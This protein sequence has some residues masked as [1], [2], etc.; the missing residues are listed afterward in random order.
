MKH[1]HKEFPITT[2]DIVPDMINFFVSCGSWTYTNANSVVAA[3]STGKNIDVQVASTTDFD[4]MFCKSDISNEA[5]GRL[6]SANENANIRQKIAITACQNFSSSVTDWYEQN[7]VLKNVSNE[8]IG[9][10]LSVPFNTTS[11]VTQPYLYADYYENQDDKIHTHTYTFAIVENTVEE[12]DIGK[13]KYYDLTTKK[14]WEYKKYVQI[15]SV[16][17]IYNL[18]NELQLG[19]ITGTMSADEVPDVSVY[20]ITSGISVT[21]VN[22]ISNVYKMPYSTGENTVTYGLSMIDGMR[23]R[24]IP[25]AS[26]S[27]K[28]TKNYTGKHMATSISMTGYENDMPKIPKYSYLQSAN[29]LDYGRNA[30]TLNCLTIALP[31]ALYYLRDPD[32]LENY[33]QMWYVEGMSF[34]S[35]K[36][37]APCKRYE[38]GYPA[39]G[40]MQMVYPAYVKKGKCGYD[41]FSIPRPSDEVII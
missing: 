30:N 37:I 17:L 1:I 9:I 3:S 12:T 21:D 20:D 18:K 33:S 11:G 14:E 25:W 26:T 19:A 34:I 35:L 29:P 23:E 6:F 4:I 32:I 5:V 16:F 15:F 8:V 10:G 38:I 28:G 27:P 13:G 41:G 36:Y 31:I 2:Q 24:N 40:V 22:A 7:N 39:S